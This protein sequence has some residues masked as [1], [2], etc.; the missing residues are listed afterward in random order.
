MW[1][2]GVPGCSESGWTGASK[3]ESSVGGDGGG[4]LALTL[5]L[6]HLN[7]VIRFTTFWIV[8]PYKK[9]LL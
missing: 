6:F 1:C 8:L 5:S 3:V 4:Y 7:Y 9:V 2:R